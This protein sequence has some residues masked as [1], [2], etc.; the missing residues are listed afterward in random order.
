[1]IRTPPNKNCNDAGLRD[2]RR[3]QF[4]LDGSDIGMYSSL[5]NS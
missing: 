2:K 4:A 3:L 5:D 1:M